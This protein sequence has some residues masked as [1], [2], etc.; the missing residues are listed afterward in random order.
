MSITSD[1]LEGRKSIETEAKLGRTIRAEHKVSENQK[2]LEEK[3]TRATNILKFLRRAPM[4]KAK[5]TM[6]E[7]GVADSMNSN[8]SRF[9]SAQQ[10][11]NCKK[12]DNI[13]I[14]CL[15]DKRWKRIRLTNNRMRRYNKIGKWHNYWAVNPLPGE[16][17]LGSVDPTSGTR[18]VIYNPEVTLGN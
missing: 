12:G 9:C 13:K 16:K 15:K 17:Q 2:P 14:Y 6:T 5:A 7:S 18:W 1:T 3:R 8:E 4:K 10:P 11:D